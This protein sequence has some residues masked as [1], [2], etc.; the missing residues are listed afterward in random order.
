MNGGT[1]QKKVIYVNLDINV[2]HSGTTCHSW[3]IQF[4]FPNSDW[5]CLYHSVEMFQGFQ[6]PRQGTWRMTAAA[7]RKFVFYNYNESY[8]LFKIVYFIKVDELIMF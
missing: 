5:L 6:D 2:L 7:A 3:W 4:V 8:I 1:G